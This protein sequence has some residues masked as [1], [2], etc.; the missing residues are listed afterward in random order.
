MILAHGGA[1]VI[2]S[3]ENESMQFMAGE[4]AKRGWVVAVINCRL[5]TNM[6]SY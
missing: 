3:K 2:E 4:L 1:K 6:A 5:G